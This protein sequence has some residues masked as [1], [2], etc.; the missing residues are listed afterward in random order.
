MVCYSL[1][2]LSV[3]HIYHQ[4]RSWSYCYTFINW[5]EIY[6]NYSHVFI[7]IYYSFVHPSKNPPDGPFAWFQDF[8]IHTHLGPVLPLQPT[9]F[10]SCT[11]VP[12]RSI[13]MTLRLSESKFWYLSTIQLR[14]PDPP[15]W[16]RMCFTIRRLSTSPCDDDALLSCANPLAD[17]FGN[18]KRRTGEER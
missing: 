3:T 14:P 11:Y 17:T 10:K 16:K 18:S 7:P 8:R 12:R 2:P 15:I 13:A 1:S 4:V 9:T 5:M 6:Y